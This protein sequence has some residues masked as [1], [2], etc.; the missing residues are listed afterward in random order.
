MARLKRQRPLE[1]L[2]FLVGGAG[3]PADRGEIDPERRVP[4]I[5]GDGLID[6]SSSGLQIS[7]MQLLNRSGIQHERMFGSQSLRLREQPSRFRALARGEGA[8]GLLHEIA[9]CGFS[10]TR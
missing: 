8:L 2:H 4:G 3:A 10:W 6:Q 9:Y 1:C 5:S 7:S